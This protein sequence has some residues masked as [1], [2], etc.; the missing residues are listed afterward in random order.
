VR[1]RSSRPPAAAVAGMA[2]ADEDIELA[3]RT[4]PAIDGEFLHFSTFWFITGLSMHWDLV[5][6]AMC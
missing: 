6:V 2:R 1:T 4:P 3:C 5:L